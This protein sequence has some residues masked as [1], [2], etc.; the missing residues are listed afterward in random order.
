MA[1]YVKISCIGPHPYVM[2]GA[3]PNEQAVELMIANWRNQLEQVL[4]DRPDLIVL[5]EVFD[6]PFMRGYPHER[7]FD[8]YR[9]RKHRLRDFLAETARD[10]NCYITYPTHLEMA[11]G[12]WRNGVQLI[13]RR[14]DIVGGYHKNHI[15]PAEYDRNGVLYGKDADLVACDFGTVAFAICF[16]LNFEALRLQ[17]ESLKPDLIVFPSM[18]HGSFMQRYWAY[19]C[20][21]YFAGAV[22]GLPCTVLNPVGEVVASSSPQFPFVTTT[23]N[24]DRAVL[25]ID[26]N[27]LRFGEMKRKYGDRLIIRDPGYL[28]AVLLTSESDSFTVDDVIAEFGLETVD[29]YFNRCLTHRAVEGHVE[30]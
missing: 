16:D 13:G 18:Y 12:S 24:L 6:R 27:Q 5:P 9:Y 15:V 19:S 8:Y 2:D 14:G 21:S 28:N 26:E 23:I 17:Y 25:H 1:N 10:N 20:R 3:I 29:G 7:I 22:A 4:P 11:D 30:K